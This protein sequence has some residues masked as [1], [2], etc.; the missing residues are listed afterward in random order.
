MYFDGELSGHNSANWA[1]LSAPRTAG[2][3]KIWVKSG[4]L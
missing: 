2:A 4:S 3:L 1:I